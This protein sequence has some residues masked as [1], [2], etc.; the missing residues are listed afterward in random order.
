MVSWGGSAT[1]SIRGL[2]RQGKGIQEARFVGVP[3]SP[4][5]AVADI[6]TFGTFYRLNSLAPTEFNPGTVLANEIFRT[7]GVVPSV[8][9]VK[10]ELVLSKLCSVTQLS[11]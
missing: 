1:G 9:L 10:Q 3:G 4:G 2:G 5:A 8:C 7:E 11:E 6:A